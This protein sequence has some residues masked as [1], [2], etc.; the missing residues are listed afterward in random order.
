MP[1]ISYI[2]GS[3]APPVSDLPNPNEYSTVVY[4]C[5]NN[6]CTGYGFTGTWQEVNDF[7]YAN[8]VNGSASATMQQCQSLCAQSICDHM[9]ITVLSSNPAVDNTSTGTITASMSWLYS[10]GQ[11][12]IQNVPIHLYDSA[13]NIIQ[14]VFVSPPEV[15]TFT[16]LPGGE[17]TI[18]PAPSFSYL[19][20]GETVTIS[21]CYSTTT[22][23]VKTT[24]GPTYGCTDPNS[25][26]YNPYANVDDGSCLYDDCYGT[27][28]GDAFIDKCGECVASPEK[29]CKQDCAGVWGGTFQIDECG[30]C[31]DPLDIGLWNLSCMDCAGVLNGPNFIDACGEC[32][33]PEGTLWNT[34]CAG[35]KNPCALNYDPEAAI[36]CK[37]CCVSIVLEP[38]CTCDVATVVPTLRVY[39]F[40][41]YGAPA[42]VTAD[43][44]GNIGTVT[45]GSG[46]EFVYNSTTYTITPTVIDVPNGVFSEEGVTSDG[47]DYVYGEVVLGDAGENLPDG[48]YTLELNDI[49]VSINGVEVV[50]VDLPTV[51][52]LVLCN[53]EACLQKHM[54]N[55]MLSNKCCECEEL[56]DAYMKAFSIYRALKIAETCVT[57]GHVEKSLKRLNKLCSIMDNKICNNC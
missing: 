50:K 29:A 4:Y 1:L 52:T 39:L 48:L 25:C 56:K 8:V 3:T 17:Y 20:N 15:F 23:V 41:P 40:R 21:D 45:I 43:A 19:F 36:E 13:G 9:T 14:T 12:Q 26:N 57:K 5:T 35:C 24:G 27:C 33:D 44:D 46:E 31:N 6:T 38:M 16:N 47:R 11:S 55:I 7:W 51:C 54:K 37:D 42:S 2:P 30:E 49:T 18:G 32:T 34:E 10:Q 53:I 28:G 22:A